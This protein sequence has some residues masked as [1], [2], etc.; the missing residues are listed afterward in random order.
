MKKRRQVRI[1]ID[2]LMLTQLLTGGNHTYA[3]RGNRVAMWFPAYCVEGLPPDAELVRSYTDEARGCGVLVFEHESFEPVDPGNYPPELTPVFQVE[4][5]LEVFPGLTLELQNPETV[6]VH[7]DVRQV[8]GEFVRSIPDEHRS[9]DMFGD[10]IILRRRE[11]A[12][13][14]KVRETRARLLGRA[15]H[16]LEWVFPYAAE[17]RKPLTPDAGGG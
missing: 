5:A 13:R 9:P 11:M 2:F 4:M 7:M 8:E 17:P 6:V 10:R 12:L 1:S 3:R 15:S 16:F 14:E